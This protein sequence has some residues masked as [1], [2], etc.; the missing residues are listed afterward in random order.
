[1]DAI[2]TIL[3]PDIHNSPRMR[4][5]VLDL[6]HEFSVEDDDPIL[7]EAIGCIQHLLMFAPEHV[8]IPEIVNRFRRHLDS[9]RRCLQLAA[10][11]A[12]IT[13]RRKTL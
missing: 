8:D 1:V 7:V 5:I 9:P 6:V 13:W 3:G 4:T 10:I 11:D 2:I 12:Q